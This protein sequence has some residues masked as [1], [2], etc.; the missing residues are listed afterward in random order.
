[1]LLL[2]VDASATNRELDGSGRFLVPRD[3]MTMAIHRDQGHRD[4]GPREAGATKRFLLC[5][6]VVLTASAP[7]RSAM[8]SRFCLRPMAAMDKA[9]RAR[10]APEAICRRA[11]DATTIA[12]PVRVMLQDAPT[13]FGHVTTEYSERPAANAWLIYAGA[14]ATASTTAK[15]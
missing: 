10:I 4:A 9:V 14:G 1:M 12:L 7:A 3:R 11:P 8:P 6:F 2:P 15:R 13:R 5:L